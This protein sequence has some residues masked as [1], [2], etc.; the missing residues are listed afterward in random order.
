MIWQPLFKYIVVF[1]TFA[2]ENYFAFVELVVKIWLG[3]LNKV[4]CMIKKKKKNQTQK[5]PEQ[6]PLPHKKDHIVTEMWVTA[7]YASYV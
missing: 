5:L 6:V 4:T 7:G 1:T 3:F 2:L